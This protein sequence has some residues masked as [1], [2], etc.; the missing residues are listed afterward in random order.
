MAQLH[1]VKQIISTDHLHAHTPA[2]GERA[3]PAVAPVKGVLLV[4]KDEPRL[5]GAHF[6]PELKAA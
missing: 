1:A 6:Q 2:D 5:P 4:V 3:F